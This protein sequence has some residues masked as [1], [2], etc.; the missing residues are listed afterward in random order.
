MSFINHLEKLVSWI[1][2]SDSE[3]GILLKFVERL[4]LLEGD[5]ILD[6]GCGYGNK[7]KLLKSKGFDILGIDV[8]E[9]IVEKNI[10]EGLNCITAREFEK[11]GEMYGLLLMSHIIEHFPPGNLCEFMDDYLDRLKPGGHLIIATPLNCSYF[12]EDF[13]HIKPYHPTGITMVF[14][15]GASQ[16]RFTARNS[17]KLVDIWF[18]K[19]PYKL[20]FYRGLY[21]SK[22]SRLPLVFNLIFGILF[23]ASFGVFGKKDGWMGLYK[24]IDG[25]SVLK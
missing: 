12:Y 22:Y 2:Y 8:N 13:D 23:H 10:E 7:M 24:K 21:L 25:A 9:N 17:M 1:Q 4:G 15:G 11:S 14:S 19:G 6:I 5:K 16:V 18:R 3:E 20:T